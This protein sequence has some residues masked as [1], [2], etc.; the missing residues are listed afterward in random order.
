MKK[1][2]ECDFT[3]TQF[4]IAVESF[5]TIEYLVFLRFRKVY[6]LNACVYIEK[7]KLLLINDMGLTF[8]VC[9]G[10]FCLFPAKQSVA[11]FVWL[12]ST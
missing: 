6:T 4:K 1:I 3:M 12:F 7:S 8:R 9:E 10:M 11:V 5:K 2:F